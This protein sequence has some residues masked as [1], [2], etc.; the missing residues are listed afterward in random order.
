MRTNNFSSKRK[1]I[2]GVA[3]I[4]LLAVCFVFVFAL[5]TTI[6]VKNMQ[7][8][9]ALAG[10]KDPKGGTTAI[11]GDK[12]NPNAAE[13]GFK[14]FTL[15]AGTYSWTWTES[16][17]NQTLSTEANTVYACNDSSGAL[18][19]YTFYVY[20]GTGTFSWK[21]DAGYRSNVQL[22][23]IHYQVPDLFKSLANNFTV[24]ASIAASISGGSARGC[25]I[26][27]A[28]SKLTSL[29]DFYNEGGPATNYGDTSCS[30][31]N[32][33]TYLLL[34][35]WAYQDNAIGN[36]NENTGSVSDI[37]VT[38]TVST[39]N[40]STATTKCKDAFGDNKVVAQSLYE[41]GVTDVYAPYNNST[42]QTNGGSTWPV[43]Y[44]TIQGNLT[45]A[46]DSVS[47]GVGKLHSYTNT[48]IN[49]IGGHQYYKTSKVTYVGTYACALPATASSYSGTDANTTYAVGVKT[50]QVGSEDSTVDGNGGGA[51]F[52][53]AGMSNG[54]S[55]SKSV[56][57][58]NELVGYATV[59]RI[60]RA[61]VEVT[62]YMYKNADVTTKAT[63]T[64]FASSTQSFKISYKGIDTTNPNSLTL[65]NEYVTSVKN[66]V[67]GLG[68]WRTSNFITDTEVEDDP[69]DSFAPYI[70]FY[71]VNR[72]N[73]LSAMIADTANPTYSSYS[74]IKTAGIKP[75]AYGSMSSF[76]Y[77]FATGKAKT[78]GGVWEANSTGCVNSGF[79][80]FRFYTVDLAGNMGATTTY[81]V[82]VDYDTPTFD[83]QIRFVDQNNATKTITNTGDVG[84]GYLANGAWATGET[85]VI[86]NL[87]TAGKS[88]VNTNGTNISGNTVVFEAGSDTFGVVF[89]NTQIISVFVGSAV[90]PVNSVYATFGK[91]VETDAS[92]VTL[93][94]AYDS[95]NGK[96]IFTFPDPDPCFRKA[97]AS[98]A[99]HAHP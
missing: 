4:T 46:V 48:P 27:A 41:S 12:G 89:D 61:K 54:A 37:S 30:V 1:A 45:G 9:A 35:I 32:N 43:W 92:K 88:Y 24:T 42:N 23:V 8:D 74:A 85:T 38:F 6:A 96:L 66:N 64:A 59:K 73:T 33:T 49:S 95:T 16:F 80:R 53:V 71:E 70:W 28:T 76:E 14:G 82:K 81:Y 11:Y 17:S 36:T 83:T 20:G 94:V 58:E 47:G 22:G 99:G 7:T 65:D 56:Y 13:A 40:A 3:L 98:F 57:V 75:I 55:Q 60:N 90:T 69:E 91:Q 77:S 63:D 15:E 10:S 68:W 26:R 72:W 34:G 78:I 93:E 44:D 97:S 79:Y 51:V 25:G 50:I 87:T 18:Y 86:L 19:S 29:S 39:T 52:N 62:T 31:A 5:A 67:N 84:L 21:A 2:K